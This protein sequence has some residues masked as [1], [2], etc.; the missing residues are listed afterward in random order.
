MHALR[1]VSGFKFML[2]R[3]MTFVTTRQSSNK[4]GFALTDPKV[5][6]LWVLSLFSPFL[7]FN[8]F[9]P[10]S[11]LSRGL[12]LC[13][14]HQHNVYLIIS[15]IFEYLIGAFTR[16]PTGNHP[17]VPSFSPWRIFPS[18]MPQSTAKVLTF[19]DNTN[20]FFIFLRLFAVF[21]AFFMIKQ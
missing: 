13:R 2:L 21:V 9:M 16:L 6:E 12:H 11:L 4:F 7:P 8:P 10:F 17:M 18:D 20:I 1:A 14:R 5:Q 3:T 19:S 15:F